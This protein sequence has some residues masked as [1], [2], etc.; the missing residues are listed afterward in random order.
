[1]LLMTFGSEETNDTEKVRMQ[2]AK[3]HS[4]ISAISESD[5]AAFEQLFFEYHQPLIRFAFGITRSKELSRDTVQDVFLKNRERIYR[6]SSK[7]GDTNNA[8]SVDIKSSKSTGLNLRRRR[9]RK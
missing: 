1:M 4:I 8:S 9:R 3:E 7:K 6:E 5:Q 2:S